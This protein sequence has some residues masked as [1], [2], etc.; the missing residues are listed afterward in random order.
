MTTPHGTKSW[1]GGGC[2]CDE[3]RAAQAAYQ[4]QYRVRVAGGE[5]TP[6]SATQLQAG[7]PGP[8]EQGV[9][10]ELAGLSAAESQPALVQV[11]Y[12][13]AR[14]LD[15]RIPTPKAG[16]AGRLVTVLDVLHKG[17]ERRGSWLSLVRSMTDTE[18][19]ASRPAVPLWIATRIATRPN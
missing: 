19:A 14:V 2:R 15:G 1:Y 11:A 6:P 4:R 12:A 13:L 18:K 3:C 17:S 9:R 16:A 8:V 7:P 10:I 5:L